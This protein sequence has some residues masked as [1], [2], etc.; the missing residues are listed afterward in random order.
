MSPQFLSPVKIVKDLRT[1]LKTVF[2][3]FLSFIG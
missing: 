3:N 2:A 1:G